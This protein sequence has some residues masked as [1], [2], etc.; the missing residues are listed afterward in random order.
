[1]NEEETTNQTLYKE[2]YDL[3]LKIFHFRLAQ[4]KKHVEGFIR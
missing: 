1:M 4:K 2:T 3:L